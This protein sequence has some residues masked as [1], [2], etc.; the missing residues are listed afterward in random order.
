MPQPIS[1]WHFSCHCDVFSM[2]VNLSNLCET[3]R[4]SIL[5]LS[6][7]YHKSSGLNNMHL[8][9]HSSVGQ[10]SDTCLFEL[11]SRCWQ[12]WI[13]FWRFWGKILVFSTFYRL[14]TFLDS[15]PLPQSSKQ[16]TCISLTILLW[17]RLPPITAM[18]GS[19]PLRSH[20]T[21]LGPFEWSRI[22]FPFQ[23]P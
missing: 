12:G 10:N 15:W 18:K 4:I 2:G 23:H 7:K 16:G 11:R 22:I 8:F 21:R 9:S 14:T 13:P 17:S 5:W 19:L 20:V 1:S 6:Y 3:Q